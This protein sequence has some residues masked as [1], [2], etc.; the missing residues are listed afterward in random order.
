MCPPSWYQVWREHRS[1]SACRADTTLLYTIKIAT[2]ICRLQEFSQWQFS[3]IMWWWL[4]D[5]NHLLGMAENSGDAS[6]GRRV[7]VRHRMGPQPRLHSRSPDAEQVPVGKVSELVQLKPLNHASVLS[8]LSFS[9]KGTQEKPLLCVSCVP[10]C[11][12]GLP[13]I[14]DSAE[15]CHTARKNPIPTCPEVRPARG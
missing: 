2:S 10:L 13:S 6:Q 15:R 12:C 4:I 8:R 11:L 5:C 3:A 7:S 14:G 1:A 9:T